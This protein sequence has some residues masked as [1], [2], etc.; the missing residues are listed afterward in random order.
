MS[1]VQVINGVAVAVEVTELDLARKAVGE[2]FKKTGEVIT[3]YAKTLNKVFGANWWSATGET[4]KLVKAEHQAFIELAQTQLNWTRANVDKV[5]SRIK[6]E[7]GRVKQS[8]PRVSGGDD[9]DAMAA[10][11]EIYGMM[12]Y[13]YR[14]QS[15]MKTVTFRVLVTGLDFSANYLILQNATVAAGLSAISVVGGPLFY[16]THE[17]AWNYLVGSGKLQLA[18]LP[19]P[20]WL[21]S[22]HAL[23]KQ[24]CTMAT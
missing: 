13:D 24:C 19:M 22:N 16:L 7:S 11:V 20:E 17:A 1:E 8:A 2:G 6:D 23:V 10:M 9:I 21:A 15:V 12:T 5:W 3:H 18:A 14:G 4:K